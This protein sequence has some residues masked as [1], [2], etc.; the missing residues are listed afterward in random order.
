MISTKHQKGGNA[1]MVPS[2]FIDREEMEGREQYMQEKKA[3]AKGCHI[4]VQVH[5]FI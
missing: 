2:L 4:L 3:Q 5:S 1:S